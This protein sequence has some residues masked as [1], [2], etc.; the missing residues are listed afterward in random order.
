MSAPVRPVVST[1]ADHAASYSAGGYVTDGL[2]S[3][4]DSVFA[5]FVRPAGG[6]PNDLPILRNASV[7]S[8]MFEIPLP[9]PAERG[10]RHV[11]PVE[12]VV[13]RVATLDSLSQSRA[14]TVPTKLR[15][16]RQ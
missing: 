7:S 12:H 4:Y 11:E 5:P 14:R 10:C 9:L 2:H 15:T 3:G 8:G 1:A 16:L 13:S 6:R